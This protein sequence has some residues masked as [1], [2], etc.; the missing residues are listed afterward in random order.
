MELKQQNTITGKCRENMKWAAGSQIN[1]EVMRCRM[2]GVQMGNCMSRLIEK[3]LTST[4]V[5]RSL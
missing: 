3:D 2:E 4:G 5:K 1:Q